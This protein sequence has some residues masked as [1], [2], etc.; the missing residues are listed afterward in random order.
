MPTTDTFNWAREFLGAP[1]VGFPGPPA[2]LASRIMMRYACL[3]DALHVQPGMEYGNALRDSFLPETG[4]AVHAA[5]EMLRLA[6]SVGL[7]AA[8]AHAERYWANYEQQSPANVAHGQRGRAQA[9]AIVPVFER[10]LATW[11][12]PQEEMTH[13][14]LSADKIKE[15]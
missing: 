7:D 10:W 9:T 14:R 15:S 5:L 3:E 1:T 2:V 13:Y 4:C 6:K 8:Y 12:T 11:G